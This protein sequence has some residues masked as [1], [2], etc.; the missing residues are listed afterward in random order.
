MF[1]FYFDPTYVLLIPAILLAIYAQTRVQTTFN[2]YSQIPARSGM[3]GAE[4][5][6]A[7]LN[8][9]HIYDVNIEPVHGQLTDYYDPRRKTLNLSEG[10]YHSTS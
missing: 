8:S 6:M 1:P 5:A 10:V 4:V 7:L 9:N 2:K 3:T